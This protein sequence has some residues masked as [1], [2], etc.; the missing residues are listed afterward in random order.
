[1]PRPTPG[2]ALR[3]GFTLVEL[4]V[5]IG[6][7]AVLLGMLLPSLSRAREA[8]KSAVCLSNLHQMGV[9]AESYVSSE[10]GRY[11]IAYYDFYDGPTTYSYCWDL[12]T[13]S[14][15]GQTTRVIAGLLWGGQGTQKIQQCPSFSGAA[16]WADNPYTGYNYNTSYIG[17]GE[18]E[19]ISAPATVSQI[20][21]PAL[22]AIFGDGQW[23]NGANKFMRAP[24]P[25]PGDA[26]FDG[27]WAGTQGF[28]HLG[29]TNV[30]FCDGHGQSLT[31]RYT[32]NKDGAGFVAPGT[33]FLS[34][35][36]R[37]YGGD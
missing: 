35:T 5:V 30:A 7:I 8:A 10:A 32:Q 23:A 11:P 6:I 12:T 31:T 29:A 37:A 13:V 28:R 25:S 3:R 14:T 17:H 19:S 9:A 27:R 16:N 26:T 36:N 18:N 15:P 2:S 1:M 20:A 24:Q 34:D 33:G 21:R 4:L 22:I